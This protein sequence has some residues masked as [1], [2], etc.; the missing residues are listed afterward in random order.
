[1]IYLSRL[2]PQNGDV[3][4]VKWKIKT[5]LEQHNIT[6]YRLWK[7]SGLAQ[8][9][10]YTLSHDKGERADL[11]TL[12]TLVDTLEKLTGATVTPNDLLEVVRDAP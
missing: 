9:T 11:R 12:G 7:E 1:M 6:P 8:K 5:L 10:V 4:I 2:R 3:A